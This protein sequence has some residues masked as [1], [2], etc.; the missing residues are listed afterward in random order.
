MHLKSNLNN[1]IFSINSHIKKITV[2]L[3]QRGRKVIILAGNKTF[4][5]H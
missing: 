5:L 1:F 3:S 2:V 4:I